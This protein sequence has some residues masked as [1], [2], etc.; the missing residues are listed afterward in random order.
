VTKSKLDQWKRVL[1]TEMKEWASMT[2]AQ[3]LAKLP[4]K[5]ECYEEEV[6]FESTK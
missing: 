1:Q 3:V 2:C 5:N 4:D 6:E